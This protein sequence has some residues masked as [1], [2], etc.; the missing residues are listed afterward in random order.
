MAFKEGHEKK[1]GRSK[2]TPNRLTKE[3]RVL[4]KSIL[5]EEVERIPEY[6]EA[7]NPKEKLDVIIKLLNYAVPKV[8][9]IN[10]GDGEPFDFD[11]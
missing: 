7:L 10:S 6:L 8:Q 4:L 5:Y 1:G 2:G 11:F 9:S 3:F